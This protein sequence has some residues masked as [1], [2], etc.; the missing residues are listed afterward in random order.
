MSIRAYLQRSKAL[1]APAL[2]R[3]ASQPIVSF[4]RS[5]RLPRAVAGVP[6]IKHGNSTR[7]TPRPFMNDITTKEVAMLRRRVDAARLDE[8]I[9]RA[10]ESLIALQHPDGHWVFELEA[11]VTIPSEFVLLQHYF[12]RIEPELQARI[13]GYIR[14][15]QGTDGGW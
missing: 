3:P 4:R 10:G 12:G 8:A 6:R 1:F 7:T 2:L 13:A 9:T 11:D 14:A 5:L 15:T